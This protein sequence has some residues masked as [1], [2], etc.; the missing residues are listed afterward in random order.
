MV[1]FSNFSRNIHPI[2]F[3]KSNV[4][5]KRTIFYGKQIGIT[6]GFAYSKYKVQTVTFQSTILD[7]QQITVK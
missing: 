4:I 3:V 7:L 1:F 2:F 6:L 5:F